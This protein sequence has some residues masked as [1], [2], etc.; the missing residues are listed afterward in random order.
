MVT[1]TLPLKVSEVATLTRVTE[2]TVRRWM[3]DGV[4]GKKLGHER[5][6]S[7][8]YRI[9]PAE[10]VKFLGASSTVHQSV[11]FTSAGLAI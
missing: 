6:P 1:N 10:L 9:P 4:K 8:G 7:G 3:L 11:Q 2:K 5:L